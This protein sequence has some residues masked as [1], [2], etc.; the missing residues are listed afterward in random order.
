[1]TS[2]TSGSVLPNDDELTRRAGEHASSAGA[3]TLGVR[4][5]SVHLFIYLFSYSNN[6]DG[7]GVVDVP[8]L[9]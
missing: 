1:M 9:Y 2:R 4:C 8:L 3:G 5:V 6:V 7:N